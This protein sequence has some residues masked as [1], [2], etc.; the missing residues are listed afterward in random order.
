MPTTSAMYVWSLFNDFA[1]SHS[2]YLLHLIYVVSVLLQ[3]I[4]R[5]AVEKMFRKGYNMM[6]DAVS[7]I[8]AKHGRSIIS[9]VC[10]VLLHAF[11]TSF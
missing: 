1:F 6:P 2:F 8:A 7:V 11:M 5:E 10:V 3:K 4:Y 9:D